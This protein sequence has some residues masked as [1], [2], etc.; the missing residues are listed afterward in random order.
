MN[1]MCEGKGCST[2]PQ[3]IEHDLQT[4]V[5]AD[6]GLSGG[7]AG[8]IEKYSFFAECRSWIHQEI[9]KLRALWPI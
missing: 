8:L 3:D 6:G 1:A 7:A 9:Y 2:A 5:S 4:E